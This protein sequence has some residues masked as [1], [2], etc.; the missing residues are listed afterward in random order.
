MGSLG[1]QGPQGDHVPQQLLRMCSKTDP[2][3]ALGLHP[4]IVSGPPGWFLLE[5]PRHQAGSF[6]KL[7]SHQI[8]SSGSFQELGWVPSRSFCFARPSSPWAAVLSYHPWEQQIPQGLG[9]HFLTGTL[10]PLFF[11]LLF[12]PDLFP[13]S[14][15][16]LSIYLSW[17]S[18][19][20]TK[21][22]KCVKSSEQSS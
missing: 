9:Q 1:S 14:C 7:L 3:A 16:C 10:K 18:N 12:Q 4:F 17:C 21:L 15:T 6:W 2:A 13:V 22:Q 11:S 5:A 19:R 8:S 20:Q